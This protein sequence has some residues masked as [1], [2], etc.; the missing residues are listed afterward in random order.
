[1]PQPTDLDRLTTWLRRRIG[2]G[3]SRPVKLAV[4]GEG[5]IRVEGAVVTNEDGPAD[6]VIT[7]SAQ[8]LHDVWND[9]LNPLAMPKG[10]VKISNKMLAL[11]MTPNLLKL[12]TAKPA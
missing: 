6:L 4:P 9:K 11:Q 7:V 10:A 3:V 8:T 1:M 5:V 2:E 12:L